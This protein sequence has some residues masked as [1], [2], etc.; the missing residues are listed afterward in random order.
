MRTKLIAYPLMILLCVLVGCPFRFSYLGVD[1]GSFFAPAILGE[2]ES[3]VEEAEKSPGAQYCP[4]KMA[5]A[6]EL[7]KRG[8]EAYWSFRK[9]DEALALL[10][11]AR[12]LAQ[13]VELCQPPAVPQTPKLTAVIPAP[14]PTPT[15]PELPPVPGIPKPPPLKRLILRGVNF[16]FNSFELSSRAKAI[17]DKELTILQ[18]VPDA[19]FEIAGHADSI[20]SEVYNQILSERRAESVKDFLVSRGVSRN[21]ITVMGYGESVPIASNDTEEGRAQ[22]RRV[23]M[24]IMR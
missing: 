9:E 11:R 3:V 24:N 19:K 13:E 6:R 20:G 15:A 18:E 8:V 23:E 17:L 7:G 2:T 22:N 14:P 1:N 4:E 10:A 5:E 12:K 16:A 21:R